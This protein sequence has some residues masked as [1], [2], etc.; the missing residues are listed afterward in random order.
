MIKRTQT[1]SMIAE[2][3]KLSGNVIFFSETHLY[4][5][6]EGDLHQQSTL[7][8]HI[9]VT[10]WVHGSVRTQGPLTI[11]G[12]VDGHIISSHKV[13]LSPRAVV[14]GRIE[15]PR[16]EIQPG[17]IVEGELKMQP[18]PKPSPVSQAA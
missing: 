15:A 7:P 3:T 6:I 10:G 11:E 18:L 5:V 12:R 1:P 17:A 16:I 14:R 13:T 8:I 9:G 2:A 4:G